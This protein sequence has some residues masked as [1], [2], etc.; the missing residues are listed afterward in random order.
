MINKPEIHSTT[1]LPALIDR[2]KAGGYRITPQRVAILETVMASHEHP[3]A[4]QVY[5]QVRGQYPM[6]SLAT[7]Y[8]TLALMKSEG[9]VV[10]LGFASGSRFDGAQPF[11]HPHLIC[12]RCQR[13]IDLDAGVLPDLPSGLDESYGFTNLSQRVDYYGLCP[14]CQAEMLPAT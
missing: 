1:R 6:T 14:Q 7:V 8:K 10:E 2:L 9:E 3:S 13:I 4:E 12:M 11:P 5:E